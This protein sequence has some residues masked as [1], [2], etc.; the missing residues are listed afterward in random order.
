MRCVALHGAVP[1]ALSS[2]GTSMK[3]FRFIR[4][5]VFTEQITPALLK[6]RNDDP[7]A[8]DLARTLECLR[9][10]AGVFYRGL[11]P[12]MVPYSWVDESID[13]PWRSQ[14]WTESKGRRGLRTCTPN[15]VSPGELLAIANE[16]LSHEDDGFVRRTFLSPL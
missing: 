1:A 14:Y 6:K 2:I 3:P 4:P 7:A 10:A 9:E 16:L 13:L 15:D 12:L 8:Q 5:L 11:L